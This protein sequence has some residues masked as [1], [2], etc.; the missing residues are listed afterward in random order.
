MAGFAACLSAIFLQKGDYAD[1]FYPNIGE[2]PI[3]VVLLGVLGLCAMIGMTYDE[4]SK[5]LTIG[6]RKGEFPGMLKER[7]FNVIPVSKDGVG[8]A[9]TVKY[10]G[11]AMK[12]VL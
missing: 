8:K 5:T 11:L 9:K 1:K 6:E 3:V 4:A 12:V 7:V 10:N 2:L